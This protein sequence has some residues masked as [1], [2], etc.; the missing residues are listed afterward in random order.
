MADDP[1]D[2][3]NSRSEDI[4]S[5]NEEATPEELMRVEEQDGESNELVELHDD[6]NNT[7][8][9]PEEELGSVH[10]GNQVF[11]PQA[12]AQ[13]AFRRQNAATQR[14]E[15]VQ[16]E[17]ATE[18]QSIAQ[19][20]NAEIENNLDTVD[21]TFDGNLDSFGHD[22]ISLK[23][24][25]ST[26]EL[27][28]IPLS[29]S[30]TNQ[31][32]GDREQ[33][34]GTGRGE[35]GPDFIPSGEEAPATDADATALADDAV[36]SEIT[37]DAITDDVIEVEKV[38]DAP[39]LSAGSVTGS[40]DSA[41]SLN[42]SAALNDLDGGSETLSV[43]ISGVP[44]G[45]ILSAGTNNGDGT[46]SVPAGQL[47]GLKITPPEN[48]SG[49]FSLT[50][51]ATSREANGSTS[52]TSS[53]F[54]VDVAGVADG[55][56]LDVSDASGREDSAIALDIDTELLDGSES[57]SVKITGVPDGATLSAGT[58][59]GDGS[60]TL[61]PDQLE[62]LTITPAPDF[63]GE[64][65][66][67][68]LVS[69]TDGDDT[70]VV[71]EE[72]KVDVEGI[73][74]APT[75]ETSNASGA[76]DSAIAL[77][78]DAGLTDS[79]ETLTV[80]ISGVPDG[81]TLSAGT[82]NGDGTWTLNPDQLEGLTITP[83]EDFSGSF[84]LGVT[85]QSAD[86][87]DVAT[88]TGSITV[89]V[90]GV[91]DAPTL[92]VSDASGNEDTAIAL[93]IDAGLTDSSEVL[94][95]T[96]SGVPDGATLSAGTDNG[97]GTWTLNPDQLEGLTITP[98]EDF[99]GS[100]DLGVTATSAD[101]EDIAKTTGS[102]TVDVAGVADAPTL[103]IADASGNED[104]AIALDIDAGLTDSSEVLSVTIS[105]VPDGATLS[106]GTDNGDGT[107]TLNPEQLEGLTITPAEDFSGSFDL[108]V[109]AAST[110]GEDVATTTG[111][112]TVD[113]AGVADEP[114]LDVSDAS[115]NEDS[116][117]ALDIDAG[118]TDSS[119]VLSITIS[120]VPDGATLSAGT[121]N[122]DGT[123]TLSPDQLEG[124]TITPAED[125]S[126][127]FDLGVTATSADGEDVA[128]TT[129]SI[130]VDVTGVADAP[131][132]ETSNASGSED[133]AIALDIDAGLTDFS[134]VL[135]VTISGVPDGAT[136]S[137]GTD[138]GD[139]TWTLNLDQLEGLTITPAE[140]F[141]GSFDLGV[142]ATS[143]DGED[144]ATTT[145]S[146]TVD[147]AGVADAPTLD[148]ADA[149][150]NEDSAIAL[151]I[152]AGLTDISEVLSVTISGV[153]DGATLS[154][155]TDN[156]DGTWTLNPDQ[157]E[158]LT[159]TPAQDF[160]GSFDLGVTATSAD[161]DDI[162]TT[163]GSITV[164]VAAV[165]D[166][167]T[168]DVADASGSEDSAIAL[169]IDAGLTDSSEVL[170]V[171]ISGVP[172]GATLSAGTDNGD[173]TWT[174][175]PD[176]LEGLTITPAEDFS[177][178]FDLG[179][180]ATSADGDD[181]AT[182][183]GSIIVD[184]AGVA[185]APTLDVA[186]ASGN[187]DTAIALDVA[188][189]LTD[190]SEVLSV[191][192]SGVPDGATLSAG[193]DNGDGTWTLSPDQLEGL[194]ITPAEDFSG[195]FD[196]GV[197][198]QS[199]DG[200][201][202]ATTTGSITVDVA[203]VADAP[204]LDVSDASGSE[205]S[206]IALDIDA[207]L[208]D[209][210]EV[211]SVTISGVP[212]GATL[213]AGTDNGDGT[214][215][216]N[217]DQLEGLTITPAE[218]FSGS[219]ELGVTATS[220]DGEDV[221]TT[222]GSITIDVVGVADAPTLD[223]AD[224]SG[225]EDGAIALDIDAGLT[226]SSEV[227][228][229]TISG[230]PDG[231]TL[232]AGTDNGDGTWTLNP[233]QLEGL[234]ITP[235]D[236]FSGSF[237][238]GVTA[239][240]AD[241]EDVATT[242]GSITVDVAGVADAPTLEV[243][244][245]SGSEDSAIA[246][247]INA[248]LT[249]SSEVL[250]V[251]ISGVPDGA[252]LSAG[253]DNGDG[254]WTLSPD[255]LEGLT[256][257]PAEDFSGSFDL[258]VAA[259]SADGEDFATTTGSITVDVAGVA[260]APTLDVSDA[261]GNEDS[262]IALD[263]DAGLTDSSEVLSVTISG[264]PDGATLS[265]GTDNGDGTW[266]LNADQLEG[267]TITPAEDF[268]GSF[269]L[270]VTATSADGEDVAT[271]TGSITVD[272]AGVADAPTLETS[273]ASGSE[274][275]AIALD[276][277][278]G[279]TDSNEALTVTISGVPDGATLSAG[280]DNGDGT[281]T[282]NPEQLEGL[283]ITPAEDFSGSFDLGV[284]ATSADGEDVATT[285]GSI[286]VDVAGVADA[287]TLDVA[288]A[289]GNE[290]SAIA[291][292]ID[293]GL[294]DS[295]EVL[296]ITI[297]GV[298]DGATLS[299]GTDNGDG[300]W[301]LNPDQLEGLT[302]T[303][304]EDFSGSFD[305]GVTAT[306]ADG[307]DVATTTGSI[308]V[309]AVGVADA[310]TLDVADASGSED[311]AI[312]LDIDAGLTDSSEVLSITISGV[313]DG[314]TL[315]AGTDNGDGTW[316]LNPDQLEGLTITPAEDFS[317]SFDLGVTA[318]STDG[319]DVAT[320]TGSIT[321]DVAGVADAP[322]LDVADASGNEDSA[323]A[324]DIDAGLTD[325]S[326]VLTITISGVPDGATLSAGTD[327][328]DGTWS[329]SPDQLEGLT[330]TPAEDFSG[331]FDLGVTATSAD[332]EDVA[333]VSGNITVDVAGVADA[334]TL[335]VA[336]ASGSED[337]AI[338]LDI[339]AGL[340][341]SSEVLSV[342]ISGV[343]DGATL[344]AGTDNGDGTWTLN[345]DQLESLTITPAEDFSGSFD[346]G[347]T[348]TSTDG[349]D[350][351][352][353]TGSITVDVAGVADAPTL[354][355]AD[356]SG[357]EDS[358]IALDIDA[359]LTDSSEVLT[360]T[361]SGVPDGATLSAGTDNGDGTWSLNPDQLEG[362]TV[363][364]AEDF[365]GSFDLGV[366]ATSADGDDVATATGSI[367]VDV[368]G[369]ADAPTLDVADASGS[370]DSAIALDIDAGLTDSSEVLSVTISGVPDGATLSAGTDNGDGTWT[371]NP[372]QLE[373]LT[374]TPADDFSGSFDLGVT[375]TSADGED[376]ATTTGSIT[377]DVAGVADAPTLDVSDASG[378]EDSAIALD[379]D[380]GLTD[381]SEVLSITI[382]GVPD[383]ATLSAGTDNGDGTWTLNPD[384]LEGLTI[385][386]AED[387]SGSFDLGVIATSAD[388]DDVA[389]TTGSITVDVAGV[390]DAPTLDV[391][392][393]SGSEDSAIA[394]DIDA[395]LTDSSEVLT[396]TI[397]GVPDGATLSAGTDNG[398]GTWT[399]SPDQL[400]GLTIT[401]AEDFSGSFDLGVTATSADGDDVATTT[402]SF[403]VDVAGVADAP[404]LDVADASGSEDSAIA[405]DIDA[406]LTDSSETLTVT[407]SGVPDGATLSAGTDNG[408]G[409]WTLNPV[410]LEGLTITPADNFSGSFDLG[411]T[412]TS[413]DGD[414]V[415]TTTGSITVDVAGVA[416]APTLDVSDASGNED[417]AIAL[418]IDAGLTDSSEV[419]SVTISGVPDGAT[420]SAGTDNGDGTWTLSPD[421]LEGLTVTLAED[422][423]G[424]FDLGVTA[425]SAD[426]EDVATTS[427][428]I[429]VDV[430]GVADAPTLD[431]ADA[432]GNEDSAIALDIDAGLTDSS[433]VL[434]ITIS[435][436]PDGATLSAGTDNGDG[437]WT[438]NPDQLEG[439]TITPAEDFSGSFDLGVTA[440]SADG[441][442]VATST[443]SITVDVEGVA[444][445]PTLD[446]A[447]A[448]GNEDSAIAL[449][450]DA[451]LTDSSEVLSVTISGVPDGA[452]LSAGTDNGDGTWTLNPGQLEGL[453]ITPADDFSGSFDLGVTATSADGDDVATT[454]G[455]ITVDVTG[456]ADAP[457][458]EVSDASG[459]EDS[460]IALDIDAGLTDGSEVLSVTISGVPDGATLSAGTNNGDGTWTLNPDQLEGLTITP[461]EDFSGSF[462]LG[463]TAQSA[464][465]EDVATTTGS[466]TVDVA[467]VADAPTLDV[468][469]ASGSEDSAIALDIDAGLTDSSEVLTI[470]I[471]GVPDGA[472]LSAGTDNGDGTWTLSPDQLEG[473]TI[474]PAEDFSGSF[475]L[476]VTATS[477]DGEDVATTTGSITIDVVGVADAPT[478][479]VADASG[480]E[481]SA[482]ALDI[483]AGL[484]DSSEVLSVTISDVPDGATL[485]A[486][487]DNGD[488]TWT[489]SPDQLEGLTI[490]PPEDFSGTFD[491]G[492][493]ATSVDGE[494]AASTTGSITVDVAGVADAPTLETANASGTEDSA[495]ALD[496]DAGLTDGSET[497]TITISGVPDG[498]SLSAGTDNG[499]GTWTLNPD[500]L[501]GLT[502]TPAEDF[503]GSFDLGVTATSADGE[504]VATTTGS[505]TVDVAGVADA[506]TLDVAD[507]SGS[508]DSA[509]ALDIDAGLTDSSETLTITISGV[510][511]GAT[512]SA[513][514]DNGDGTWTLNPDQLEGLTITPAEDF[515][516][517]FDL[518]VTA[519]SADGDDV[520]TTTGS[521]T[522]D[523][524]GVADAPTLDVSDASGNEDSAIALDIDAGLTD[525]SEVLSVTISGVPDGATLS[526]G[527]DNGDGT[528]TLNPDQL[529]GLTITPAD[530]FSGSFD[531]GVR[532]QS[533][534]GED[535]ATTTGS[536]TVDV[537]GVA[538]APTLEVSD[539]SGNEDSAIA[540]DIDAGLTD[541]S[542]V[543]SV[544][545]SGVPDGAT[546]SAGT[547]NGDGTWTLNP[548]QLEGL[549][550]T[551]AEDFSGSFDLGVTATSA[552]GEDVATT[553]GSITVDVAGVSDAPTLDVS[554]ASG[555]EDSAIALDIDA[556]LA[557][558][559]EVL[560]ITISGV[561]DGATL[562]AGTD[563]G[564]GTWTLNPDQLEGLTIT[565]ADDFSGSF[566]L[567]VT[568]TSAD[569][570]DVATT[571]GS[572]T[573]DVAGVVDTPTL[574]V[575]DASGSEDSA[576]ALDI[577]AGLTDS[578][579]VLSITISGV[580]DGATL[581]AGTDN[582]D[583]TWTLN[584]DQL[585]GLTITPAEDFSGSFDLGVTATS[586]DGEDV[587]TTTGSIT[588]DVSGVADAPRLDVADAS[589]NE[590][591][592]IALDI[593]AG[594]ADSSEVL[595][596][597]ISGVP[598]GATLSAGTDNGDGTWTL[599]PDQLEGLT[600]TPAEDFSGSFDLGVTA[601]SA[602]GDDVATT[603]G[604]IT[605]DV[606]GVADAPA[607]DVA[608]ASGSEDS[609]IAL[610]ID[611]GLT[612]SSEVLTVTISGVP[613]GATLSAGT[614]NGDGTWTLS[615]DQLEGLTITPAEDFSG[616][617]D[618][619][620][621]ATSADGEDVA[622]TTGSITVDVAGVADAPT[623][624]VADASGN[625][626]SAIALDIDA[627]LTDSSEVLSV[628]I[629][630]VPDGAT[631]SAGTDNGDGTWTLNPDQ[632]EGLTITP[633]EDFS[634][635]FDLGLT[636]TSAN[637]ND[638]ATTTGLITVDVSAIADA[639][640][641][642]VSI[643]E[644][645][646]T[647]GGTGGGQN[648]FV[649]NGSSNHQG[650]G[651]DDTFVI[652]RDLNMNENFD[653]QGGND[654]VILNGDTNLGNNIRL[655]DGND[656]LTIKG[657]IGE[658]SA[659]D[660]G[661]GSDV[662]Y[663]GKASTS[664]SLQNFT[665]NQGVINTQIIDLDTGKT[666]TV[667]QIE[668][669]SFGDGVV[670]GNA[671]LVQAPE[672]GGISYP[673]TIEAALNDAD[674]S[675]SLSITITGVPEGATLSAGTQNEDGSWSL[676]P[677]DLEGLTLTTPS[678]FEGSIDLV[679][680]ATAT[681][682]TDTNSVSVSR[683]I[684]V[685]DVAN[686]PALETSDASGN[687][688]SA[689]ALDIDAA[690][691][692][693]AET[694]TVTISGVPDGATLSAGT[695]NGDGTWT[696]SP[697]QL[698]GL[699][700]TPPED[701]S[702][703][704]DL[705]VT[706]TSVD[707]EDAASTTG[708][709]TVDVA[710]VADAPTL[711]TANASGTEDSAIALDIDAGLTDSSE[712]LTITISG[713]PEGASL[714]AGTDN[715]DGTWSL[716]SDDL[717]G[718]TIT[719]PEDFSGSFDLEITA[720]T[721]DGVDIASVTDT[722]MV[723]VIGDADLPTLDVS[724]ALGN[725]DSA[726]A[727]DIDAGLTDFSEVLSIT[728][729]GVPDG[730]TL[731]AGTDNGDGTWTLNPEQ[732]EGLTITP[733]ED[734]SG[735]FDL[736]VTATSTDGEDVATTTGSITVDVAGVADAPT[737]DVADASGSEDSAIALDIDA[738]LTD[739]S[740]VLSV[741]I[742]GIPDGATL[743]AGTDNGDG[744]WTLSPDQLEGLT[745]TPAEDFSG[746]FD[747]G[748]TATSADGEDVAT[749][750]GSI[751]VDVA[752]VA[753]APTLDV[754]D[755]SG[756][757]DSAIALDIDAG[758][759][760]G[761]EV[762][763][764]TIS[765]VPD[766][767]TLSAGT[768]NGDGTWTLSPNQLEG[769]TI[770]PAEDFSG[771]FE[772]GVT[773]TSADGEDVATT[774]G[775]ITV[776]VAGVADAPTLTVSNASGG[777]GSAIS[778]AIAAG[779]TDASEILSVTIA[780]VPD[781]A[782]LSAGTDNGD[783]TWTLSA[784][785]L[786]G[787]KIT[788]ADNYS[789]NFDL[790]VTA[791]SV[792]GADSASISQNLQVEVID[793]PNETVIGTDGTDRITTGDGDDYINAKSGHDTIS[794]GG[795]ADTVYG[796]GGNDII[797]SGGGDD[798]VFGG[799]GKDTITGGAGDDYINAGGSH[800]TVDGGEGNDTIFGG[801]GKDTI[802]GGAGDDYIDAGS[803]SDT[804]DGGAGNDTILG[805][806]GHDT[807]DGGE[808]TDTLYGGN[809]NDILIGSGDD[810][811][812][813]ESGSDEIRYTVDLTGEGTGIVDGGS[814]T[815]TLKL[816]LTSEQ[817]SGDGVLDALQDLQDHI[818][819]GGEGSLTLEALGVEV[820]NVEN[821]EIY[822]DGEL[823]DPSAESP[824][825]SVADA[826]G[827]E[828]TS[829]SLD[830]AAGL[831]DSTETLTITISG[832]PDGATLS[833]GTDN[834][835][836]TWTLNSDQLEGLTITPPDDYSGSFDLSVT[837]VST[838][839]ADSTSTSDV[840]TVD[841]AGVADMP[842]LEVAD[843]SG[844][845]D[846]AISLDI[847]AGLSDASEI[848]SITIS[849]VPDGAT[850]S[851]GTDNGD[852][853]WTL[854]AG[855]L[856]GL[857]ITPP[858]DYSGGFDLDV[859]VT[860]TD[861]ND[862]SSISDTITVG[863]TAVADAP[864]LAVSDASGN[865]DSAISLDISA[866]LGDASETLS[867][868][869]SG[870]PDGATLSAGT[871]NGD[872]TWT[873]SA[874]DLDGL[875]ITPPDDYSGSFD[876]NVTVTST[877]GNDSASVNDTITVD[878]AGVADTPTLEVSDA[879]GDEGNSVPLDI[880]AAV[881][882]SSE[883]LSVT[884]SGVPD[885]ARLS[886]GTNNGDGSWTLGAAQLVGLTITA[887]S[888][889]SGTFELTVS[890]QSRDGDDTAT[891]TAILEVTIE[892]LADSNETL[893]GTDANETFETGSGNDTIGAG[894][895]HDTVST[896]VG[897]DTIWGG[898]GNDVIYAG[899][900][901]DSV[902][903]DDGHDYIDAGSGNDTVHG[904]EG[905]NTIYGGAGNDYITAGSGHDKIFASDGDNIIYAN[906]GNNYIETGDGKD[907]LYA[908]GGN[909]TIIGGDGDNFVSA[910]EGRNVVWTGTG[911]DTISSGSGD[912]IIYDEGG[913]NK[914]SAG[915]GRNTVWTGA[916]DDSISVG[917]GDD[918]IFAGDGNNTIGAGEGRNYIETG[919]GNDSITAGS[920]N[921]TVSAGSGNDNI[922]VGSGK[923]TVW[924]GDGND[925]I[926]GAWGDDTFL[927]G[928][929]NDI[930]NADGGD[931]YFD[932]GS[933][934]DT[935]TG[936]WGKDT[937][938][939]GSGNDTLDSGGG[940]DKLYGEEGDDTL[941]GGAGRDT[942]SGGDGNDLLLGGDDDDTLIGGIGDDTLY[943]GGGSD[944]FI[945][946]MG[947]GKDH[948][949]GGANGWTTDTIELHGVGG[950]HLDSCDWTLIL[951]EGTITDS[952]KHSLELSTDSSGTI[953]F[954]DGSELTFSNV[955]R[956]EW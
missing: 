246:L 691:T 501:E 867:V 349:E 207:G 237:D 651:G 339:N 29:T 947:D 874:G 60:W 96:I 925:S 11:N 195:S 596:V 179:V 447:D 188:A 56:T 685:D 23:S 697:D 645:T 552:D 253:T 648:D 675:E 704:F 147:V 588:V 125:F 178:S 854:S 123:W 869:I 512:L 44:E 376:V 294:T 716:T 786:S 285:T 523:V 634:G 857:T 183:T 928:D 740:E 95:V 580:P 187:E 768:D 270:G 110:D 950:G 730:A 8:R 1:R 917:S 877:D 191:I 12:E 554:D 136:L 311:S 686:A 262:A 946:N 324:L 407:I 411:V 707:G 873:L 301:T 155:G 912:D 706:A 942:L 612:D 688:D 258:G 638:V 754:S 608:D 369:V 94:T 778:L 735:S 872:G 105:G 532:A 414:D 490:T 521:I 600:I 144:V 78:I 399:L 637:G 283:T 799:S 227:L 397:S 209:S 825:L 678:D 759:T 413:A 941:S 206:A 331:S 840:I 477:A 788:P 953:V 172:D 86:G 764:V 196:L 126:G 937:F 805:G 296:T 145:G 910:G 211:L 424:S 448:F 605:V 578:S 351:A 800:D 452:T 643:G 370:E 165:A 684:A 954:S 128:T 49:S 744:T 553:T 470:T 98:A 74:D 162:A 176:Q 537:A 396:V 471:S 789:G 140:D 808:G 158:G 267:L 900:G 511:D 659:V 406:G 913:D 620:V 143:A 129:G 164:D 454:T 332:G 723:N 627:G 278:A 629:S 891:T 700:I 55:A 223:V 76:E 137:A 37:D 393:A 47:G 858:E 498:A 50:V 260:D 464:D 319:E 540:L 426:G 384:Q 690:L 914:I 374:I 373:G 474:T 325:S 903:G 119:E 945:F 367:T 152:D 784:S 871:D 563:N 305:L 333:S 663:L 2:T 181:V 565:P 933:G 295:S 531:L 239:T 212:D 902:T 887:A 710:G 515:S 89:E 106:A 766:G 483:D 884:I 801:G 231:A 243:S 672:T 539:A 746:S 166:A 513:G 17:E 326:E 82:D 338:A 682:G 542:E 72:I 264:V 943:G 115:G 708:S 741:T 508:E 790:T 420:L 751:T 779:L 603:T 813:G 792:D 345:P 142:T 197:T 480:S 538:D 230:V 853:T 544:T 546:L 135:T 313:P 673:V 756:S 883:T 646:P 343:P 487:T 337:S 112:I 595:S 820:D 662:L 429:T 307:E 154:A 763:S 269:D 918:K 185:D 141:S 75:L 806:S 122:G 139:G 783:G 693:S 221:A 208:T 293:A 568:A 336:D 401:P 864:D 84:D 80:T 228:T 823:Y 371:L 586:A 298:P 924:G 920:D 781:G 382:S 773:A 628:T 767:A 247:D 866:G 446:V 132:L 130:T 557:D 809:S 819:S 409:T 48:Y 729:S 233:D 931:N 506:P 499:D 395:G 210:S 615:P 422:F 658:T 389:T 702:G 583:G 200:D 245:A 408:D 812:Y 698:E 61:S 613:D 906:E 774:T 666:L 522:V 576:I 70:A 88:T 194:T 368:A 394:L 785:Q 317:G 202:I 599:N 242:T 677:D 438:L 159:I 815:D 876:L 68:V 701:F 257:T 703:T 828:D 234:T 461:A 895:G 410:Q 63:S 594:L 555:S 167:P 886:A 830:I 892:E 543:L 664:Y 622:T 581:S 21:G 897:N 432:S 117:I 417:S 279:L 198:A 632:L 728:I 433:E 6:L 445:A 272:V 330:I 699:T 335:D 529:E 472:T 364:P 687:E 587:A 26:I 118:L 527:T 346:L 803:S 757:E 843:A 655:G 516:G 626:D 250:S 306:S 722:V 248:G 548:D 502:I 355:V 482:I 444:D 644:G 133:S 378:N 618:L 674:G 488:G 750:T 214:W 585:E 653:L 669:I 775:S 387:F 53:S 916:G 127:S 284:T 798:R 249:D 116:A 146:I 951:D 321:V 844:N 151:E 18:K 383:G 635:S 939:G 291:L 388:G 403:T 9:P 694:L 822:V 826:S 479:D 24:D 492:V 885:G 507:A 689:I 175:S 59:N 817:L 366:T 927:G 777:E 642:T 184:V 893:W 108:G 440:T 40:E 400:E 220:A 14:Q 314:A 99:S 683:S 62:G 476:G 717:E 431:V 802:T 459:N 610:D 714:S 87:E 705:G 747:L 940:D 102:I 949:D 289:S 39:T 770:T 224:A 121:D 268:S 650:T 475:E 560:S 810:K 473:L 254:T 434:S 226:D 138:N 280:T 450:I 449:D 597:T 881:T 564:D 427:G 742:S 640:S 611:A 562:S 27:P 457:T 859:T 398:D 833:A 932:G 850:L 71:M 375:A 92:D 782:S 275:S 192:I 430:A 944:L 649:D 731:S 315:S 465:G 852:G 816:Y 569:G 421:Q 157:L 328:G 4:S 839:G 533:A 582:G 90:A 362:L 724:D 758:L 584:P 385:T 52:S 292:D 938:Y 630:G 681:D 575:A 222:T 899:D 66:L 654:Q 534:D 361:I 559:S 517:S 835:D 528:W 929:G 113:V 695:D 91:A 161:G 601:T 347:V 545:I 748:V 794:S 948:V 696:L 656:S 762:L 15:R 259:Q 667:N 363:T 402:G 225:S 952:K 574:D 381:S 834:G 41:I 711:E 217:P 847:S 889:Y 621:T 526:A 455:S 829:I 149:S 428:S 661:S 577:D 570:E 503:S 134:E 171:T 466:I 478:L 287:P 593:D 266:T 765:G 77:N 791:T 204:T 467:G 350:V 935:L 541:S 712:T 404:T 849:G 520:A 641:L 755:A 348:A 647:G 665:N 530:D 602:D 824:T 423:S 263:I 851:A 485:S 535:V 930:L 300:T 721:Q 352:T 617:F 57:I 271:T 772:I 203:G 42:V 372:D 743:S 736:G 739:S 120:G 861:G 415:A 51:T 442:D 28:E 405:L 241:G 919:S 10:Y 720:S 189:G 818:A 416:D 836:G 320:A 753:D 236:D 761:S 797:D 462:D 510:P 606:A 16:A 633:A 846:S 497:L 489:L 156:G 926:H 425:Q 177:G 277:N 567:G 796:G 888:D 734:F 481:D 13:Q 589:G 182:T 124:L 104:S 360:V 244:D 107:W 456:V 302:I 215:T 894:G 625:E 100:F 769:L 261:S 709:I 901:D 733:A 624:D 32:R 150:G 460:A 201:D 7:A 676:D 504:D 652:D 500:Q 509:I 443:G 451:G 232:S 956:I 725:E 81:A 299:A 173:G 719:P 841:V 911:N 631:L 922:D 838:S 842:S 329:L 377:V 727:L 679:V 358:A 281:W 518:G 713:V 101:G 436:V 671:D 31:L 491:L 312:A 30:D 572:I 109:T 255:Q 58:N 323:I 863:V 54:T 437:T 505:I 169:D 590:D 199:A 453:T 356:A 915:E 256:I 879:S 623:L 303:P 524:T 561:P 390:A 551:P 353:T 827:N 787:L 310:P 525:G 860:S 468:S 549:T 795:G 67:S 36:Q 439:L 5:V 760:D 304:A 875:S 22:D 357:S 558:S 486:G 579:E 251:T 180:T 604:S 718:L 865:E 252:T 715:G 290:D 38:A 752:G 238:L 391:A 848:L 190:S 327:N 807:L 265:A 131:T 907:T 34:R 738:G 904:G 776:D 592:A 550:I 896:N 316:T 898:N 25:P 69:T 286:T 73:A 334:P 441:E 934:N 392:D 870:V 556:G 495:I 418:D 636:A 19:A 318:T 419:L 35:R 908:G 905:N 79:S 33:P 598:D 692:D 547:D 955:E 573:V 111:S 821:L 170:S 380:A 519:T 780:G 732:L 43:V 85:A 845:E 65:D 862:T 205:D 463:V 607:L 64:I 93:D 909:D 469:D 668:A 855:D 103:D 213:S 726:I 657:D 566:D 890:V 386:P 341:D 276:I 274:D 639:P 923:N 344:S 591:S 536:I 619:G 837:A 229:V 458:L 114:T 868:T 496:I 308:T 921:D 153:P 174:L 831:N 660:G 45:A 148:V 20:I 614:D 46:W 235:A 322:T 186:D 379:I 878:V 856:D 365:S 354:D 484:T 494:D 832:V 282:L 493:T 811:L 882:D 771:S 571:T 814:Q 83:A 804:V 297:S 737:L 680:T 273:N 288:D 216:L 342:T 936:G 435:G 240:S 340:T 218:D 3:E 745:I 609:A 160:S 616:S 168:L 97:D 193:T 670:V 880:D 163:T 219:F 514:T 412:A 793:N 749:T 359:G 309:D